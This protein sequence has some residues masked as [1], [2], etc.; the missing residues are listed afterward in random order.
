MYNGTVMVLLLLCIKY[1]ANLPDQ[2]TRILS[3]VQ[4]NALASRNA[5][6]N[7]L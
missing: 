3:Q 5:L 1:L 2:V 6:Y 4:A 7:L